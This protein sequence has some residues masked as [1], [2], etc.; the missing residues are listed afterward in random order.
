[1][2][3]NDTGEKLFVEDWGSDD[4]HKVDGDVTSSGHS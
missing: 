3:G 1:M 2:L 4:G